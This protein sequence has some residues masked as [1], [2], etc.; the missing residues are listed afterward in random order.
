MRLAATVFV[1]MALATA[2]CGVDLTITAPAN[3]LP[4][5]EQMFQIKAEN[6]SACPLVSGDAFDLLVLPFVPRGDLDG[7]FELICQLDGAPP[8]FS[9]S[10]SLADPAEAALADAR[11]MV[12]Q[13]AA[14][15][16]A[17]MATCSGMG[18]TCQQEEE[19]GFSFTVCDL[20]D[21]A[22][23]AMTTL[24]CTATVP[25]DAS[26]QLLTLAFTSLAADGVCKAG[27]N[28]G[29]ACELDADC[30]GMA[31]SCGSGICDGGM[32][33]TF[34]CDGD[35]D[36][37]GG[38]C[39]ACDNEFGLGIACAE[40]AAPV[41]A[42]APTAGPWSLAAGIAALTALGWRRLRRQR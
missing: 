34:G 35:G 16:V 19:G 10:E 28:Q 9:V 23:G 41:I 24:D 39:I 36:C 4:N 33:D 2:G 31:D 8:A 37:M 7:E 12:M 13:F 29:D 20:P 42:K 21:I 30:S 18:A 25:A 14:S 11:A 27:M 17:A 6:V 40:S 3:V 15:G 1:G 38:T 5:Q 26:G 32:N 22:P